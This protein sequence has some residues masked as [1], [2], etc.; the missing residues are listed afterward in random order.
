MMKNRLFILHAF[1]F[2][3]SSLLFADVAFKQNVQAS[4]YGD[5]FNGRLT[6]NGETF[7]MNDYTCAHKTLPFNTV[8]KVTNTANGKSVNV[9]VNDRGPFVEGREIDVSKAAAIALDMIGAG[10]ATVNIDLLDGSAPKEVSVETPVMPAESFTE[11]TAFQNVPK[12]DVVYSIQLG[13]YSQKENAD[14]LAQKLLADGFT[15]VVYQTN[16]RITR[17]VIKDIKEADIES[18]KE[19]LNMKGYKDYLVKKR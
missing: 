19:R 16:G 8:L 1:M 11:S 15:N 12:K 14:V 7:N 18:V 5:D 6:A 3:T 10:T 17:V 4:Y 9:R 2:L 13:A